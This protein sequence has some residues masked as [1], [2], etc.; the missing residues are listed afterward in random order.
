MRKRKGRRP[1]SPWVASIL[2]LAAALALLLV[3]VVFVVRDV[4]VV[5]NG[6]LS[7]EDVLRASGIR[8][9]S[10]LGAVD[11]DHVRE[12]VEED[13]RM[14]FVSLERRLPNRLILTVRQR[15][16]DALI[17]QGGKVLVVDSDGY[18]IEVADRLPEGNIP[19]VTGMRPATYQQGS[20]LDATDGRLACMK[21]VVE[22]ARAR[23]ATPYIAE[24]DVSSVKNL[25]VIT[26]TG[27]TVVLGDSG[28]MEN[29]M[30]WM[31]GAVADLE[32]R[33]ETTGRLDV[34]SG[35]KADY[36]PPEKV[37]TEPEFEGE[38]VRGGTDVGNSPVSGS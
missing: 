13:G 16:R 22:A 7:A 30:I 15:S 9:G 38:L 3:K 24:I 35:S 11:E 8:M 5:G 31:V 6:S 28:N 36:L 26:R 2:L 21:A 27:L 32:A 12:C 10:R 4:Q 23:G 29:K 25:R 33:G 14:A 19:Y 17:L 20:Q 18:V 34:A 1:L 37:E